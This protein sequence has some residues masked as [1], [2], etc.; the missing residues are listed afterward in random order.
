VLV[1][2]A[3]QHTVGEEAGQGKGEKSASIFIPHR[4]SFLRRMDWNAD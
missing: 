4:N 1:A 2:L 3:C